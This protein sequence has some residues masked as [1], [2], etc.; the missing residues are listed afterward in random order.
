MVDP[1]FD[2]LPIHFP[3]DPGEKVSWKS[4]EK[5]PQPV[6]L[7]LDER[8]LMLQHYLELERLPITHPVE[9]EDTEGIDQ[10]S[11]G[12]YESDQS[13]VSSCGGGV[14]GGGSSSSGSAIVGSNI[15]EKKKDPRE[16]R[17]SQQMQTVAKQFGSI[18]KSMGKKLKKNF[19]IGKSGK[20][21][22]PEIS[23]KLSRP[24][25][26][27]GGVTQ[28]TKLTISIAMLLER[29]KVLCARLSTNKT[30]VQGELIENYLSN[31][32]KRFEKEVESRRKRGEEPLGRIGLK[33]WRAC[34]STNQMCH[35]RL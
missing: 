24:P 7:A 35:F 28:S 11:C 10:K 23:E 34:W 29:D 26:V 18:G 9:L 4:H 1:N 16:K 21:L 30:A 14:V 17:M 27:G 3:I 6:E 25:C 2:L 13:D 33:P 22:P 32:R 15:K 20:P 19:S 8:L 5:N 12:S 31:A